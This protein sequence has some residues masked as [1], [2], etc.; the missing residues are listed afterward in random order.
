MSRY[1]MPFLYFQQFG[2]ALLGGNQGLAC[3]GLDGN[4]AVDDSPELDLEL[5]R[6]A[7]VAD[8]SLDLE[9]A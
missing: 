1:S 2:N 6:K 3:G 9:S 5:C 4:F 8:C 7:G